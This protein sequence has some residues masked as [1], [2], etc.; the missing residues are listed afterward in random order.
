MKQKII[1]IVKTSTIGVLT[2]LLLVFTVLQLLPK[3]DTG[4]SLKEPIKVYSELTDATNGIYENAVS[5]ILF[6]ESDDTLKI[7]SITV[8]L[9]N[10]K[11]DKAIKIFLTE[12]ETALELPARMQREFAKSELDTV[13]YTV[14]KSVEVDI[15]GEA[16]ALSNAPEKAFETVT[17]ILIALLLLMGYLLYRSIF[18]TY[19]TFTEKK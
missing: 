1:Q 9:T 4:L 2:V 10:G 8:T 13:S 16:H 11:Q 5:G 15:N 7:N 18:T 3:P 14:V 19:Y 6:N 17:L 12:D